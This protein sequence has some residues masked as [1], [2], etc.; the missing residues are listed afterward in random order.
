MLASS[1]KPHEP[2]APPKEIS[3]LGNAHFARVYPESL[4]CASPG[5]EKSEYMYFTREFKR[6]KINSY[7]VAY[8][9]I[10]TPFLLEMS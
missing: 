1:E 2:R 7:K 4:A 3:S 8:K 9:I 10:Y 6:F 5:T